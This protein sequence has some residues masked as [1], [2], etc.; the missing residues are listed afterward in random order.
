MVALL[1][2]TGFVMTTGS[3]A[4]S[5]AQEPGAGAL[6]SWY[7][8]NQIDVEGRCGERI[9]TDTGAVRV[10]CRITRNEPVVA[11]NTGRQESARILEADVAVPAGGQPVRANSY[12]STDSAR[13]FPKS[14][15]PHLV[16]PGTSHT[17]WFEVSG[18]HPPV[19][20]VLVLQSEAETNVI[21]TIHPHA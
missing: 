4:L 19:G 14:F 18:K 9:V 11:T 3:S 16:S 15:F 10:Q 2:A 6:P 17:L 1:T 7:V 13:I 12:F 20:T 5:S 21:L 8:S